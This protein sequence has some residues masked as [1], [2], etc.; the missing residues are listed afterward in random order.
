[1]T[2]M[3]IMVPVNFDINKFSNFNILS[4]DDDGDDDGAVD[5]AALY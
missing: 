4:L 1:M 5:D 3:T 2:I